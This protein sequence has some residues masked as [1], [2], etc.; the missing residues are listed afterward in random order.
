MAQRL[1]R[2]GAAGDDDDDGDDTGQHQHHVHG[3]GMDNEDEDHHEIDGEEGEEEI[4]VTQWLVEQL[5][6]DKQRRYQ[7][8]NVGKVV[9]L[10]GLTVWL[11]RR[12]PHY[13]DPEKLDPKVVDYM[14][15]QQR[16]LVQHYMAQQG[17]GK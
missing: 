4:T 12:F 9:F 7:L 8:W 17:A 1:L 5:W 14:E 13:Q 16:M 2:F 15:M 3:P 6:K 10:F 11:M